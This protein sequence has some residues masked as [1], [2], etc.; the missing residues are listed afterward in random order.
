MTE[1]TNNPWTTLGSKEVYNN[2]WI[3]V[4]EDQ[5]VNPSGGK[6]IYGVVH[7]KGSA[8]GIIPLDDDGNTWLVG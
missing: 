1:E 4:R 7:F 5:I 6:G 8:V 2:N 3:S